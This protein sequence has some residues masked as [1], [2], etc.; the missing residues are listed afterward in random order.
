MLKV[1]ECNEQKHELSKQVAYSEKKLEEL[2]KARKVLWTKLEAASNASESTSAIARNI[3]LFT[4]IKGLR[5][6]EK[7]QEELIQQVKETLAKDKET[8]DRLSAKIQEQYRRI[9]KS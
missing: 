5:S 8:V 4:K 3:E 7:E 1:R 2:D 6:D 9:K